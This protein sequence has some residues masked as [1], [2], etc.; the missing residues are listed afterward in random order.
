[1]MKD[2]DPIEQN[3]RQDLL[4]AW[5]EADGRH[6]RSHPQH[7]LYTGLAEQYRDQQEAA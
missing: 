1:M 6:D 3:Q 7:G 2:C 5:Y 4:E